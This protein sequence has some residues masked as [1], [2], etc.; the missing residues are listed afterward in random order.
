MSAAEKMQLEHSQQAEGHHVTV[1]EVP[2]EDLKPHASTG[3]AADTPA[4]SETATGKQRDAAPATA[5]A[6]PAKFDIQ[7]EELFPSLGDASATKAP[8]SWGAKNALADNTNGKRPTNGT[9]R[10]ATP[11]SGVAAPHAKSAPSG[12]PSVHL[13]GVYSEILTLQPQE[14]KPRDQLRR[15]LEQIL[16]DINRSS[17]ATVRQNPVARGQRFEAKGP[18]DAAQ[19]ALRELV[20]QIG[21][22]VL[23]PAPFAPPRLF[24]SQ[25]KQL[26]NAS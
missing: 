24:H 4:L 26:I 5:P 16:Q 7:S 20:K 3:P 10:T 1:E 9:S 25:D 17:R 8:T 2:D 11:A 13:P 14:L 23:L 19:Q 22:T 21:S 18:Q 6:K 15:P 12:V